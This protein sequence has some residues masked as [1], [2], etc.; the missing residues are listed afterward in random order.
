[1]TKEEV[2]YKDFKN[3]TVLAIIKWELA[4]YLPLHL[5][6]M[7]MILNDYVKELNEIAEN[8]NYK[9]ACLICN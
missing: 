5:M 8:N 4:K 9:I 1:M 3:Y 2:I 7:L 6:N